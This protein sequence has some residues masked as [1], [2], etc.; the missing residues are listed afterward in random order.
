M[1]A[2]INHEIISLVVLNLM[3]ITGLF[4]FLKEL[5]RK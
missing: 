3:S 2:A 4:L 1:E 5:G